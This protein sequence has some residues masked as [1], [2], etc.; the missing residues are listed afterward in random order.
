[1]YITI[2][3]ITSQILVVKSSNPLKNRALSHSITEPNMDLLFIIGRRIIL[4][5]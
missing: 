2:N 1:M 4:Y 3:T 5:E